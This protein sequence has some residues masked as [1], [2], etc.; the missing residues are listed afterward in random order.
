MAG[1]Q[2][3]GCYV[4]IV[5]CI[6]AT[7]GMSPIIGEVKNNAIS[8]CHRFID[9][10]E[11]SYRELAQL[12]IKVIAFRNYGIDSEPMIESDFFVFPEQERKLDVFIEGISAIGGDGESSNALEAIERAL[13]SKWTTGGNERRHIILLYTNNS[14]LKLGECSRMAQYPDCMSSSFFD[15]WSWWEGIAQPINSTYQPKAGRFVAFV[16]EVKPW[17]DLEALNRFWPVYSQAGTDA[18]DD[19]IRAAIDLMCSRCDV[20]IQA[21]LDERNRFYSRME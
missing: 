14:T 1:S 6:D 13:K 10:M 5:I 18:C 16:P 2:D 19:D 7:G 3:N 9:S 20:D 21:A 11:E 4:D 17:V 8:L 15:L 12:R